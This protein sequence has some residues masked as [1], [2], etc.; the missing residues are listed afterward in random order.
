MQ[1]TLRKFNDRLGFFAGVIDA[2]TH[3][4]IGNAMKDALAA[5]QAAV[6][7]DTGALKASGHIVDTWSANK[8]I[9]IVYDATNTSGDPYGR[10]VEFGTRYT[11]SQPFLMPAAHVA[12]QSV[13]ERFTDIIAE[14]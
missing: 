9:A 14:S 13:R 8:S 12:E 10:Y 1:F 5:S 11:P 4:I 7:V 3:R 2:N 6:P